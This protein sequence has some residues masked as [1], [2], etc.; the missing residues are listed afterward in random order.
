MIIIAHLVKIVYNISYESA[1]YSL[2]R[3]PIGRW[4]SPIRRQRANLR[5][6]GGV[7]DNTTNN[8]TEN[9]TDSDLSV[10]F[11]KTNKSIVDEMIELLS[12]SDLK[13]L[14][15]AGCSHAAGL[16]LMSGLTKKVFDNDKIKDNKA[17]NF[18]FAM[19]SDAK[20]PNASIESYMSVIVNYISIIEIIEHSGG[21]NPTIPYNAEK[22]T[23]QE[24]QD[25]LKLIKSSISEIIEKT[26]T[27]M[28]HH[29][30][31]VKSVHAAN[32]SKT[33]DYFILNYDTLIE[34]AL[35]LATISHQDGFSGSAVGWWNP[36]SY[37]NKTDAK[38]FKMHGSID[39]FLLEE[40]CVPKR[41]RNPKIIGNSSERVLIYPAATKYQEMRHEP[42]SHLMDRM[43][44]NLS[45]SGN[46]LAICGYSFSDLH[47][48]AEIEN[49]LKQPKELTV[50]AFINE[51]EPTGVLSE[52][53]NNDSINQQ[54]RVYAKKGMFHGQNPV[55]GD[56]QDLEWG[57]FEIL[58]RLLRRE[59]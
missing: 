8:N 47:I 23:K 2:A 34:D 5:R 10:L 21:S 13:F 54:V 9:I 39:W 22:I 57:K 43:K 6:F 58:S 15:G 31:F 20:S 50:M 56:G 12:R 45:K 46:V 4:Q 11:N 59:R 51:D 33:I 35:G 17:M 44:N 27:N 24:F 52:W 3:R 37:D 29:L 1:K 40:D 28:S 25:L 16:P 30:R 32:T 19:F 14:L 42:F 48:N 55:Q 26:E 49:A 53:L 18:I 38:V 7:M 36:D 41:V